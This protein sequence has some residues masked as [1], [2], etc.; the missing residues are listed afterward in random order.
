MMNRRQLMGALGGFAAGQVLNAQVASGAGV[1]PFTLGVA[2][3]EPSSEGFVLWTRLAV[4]PL[5]PDGLGGMSHPVPVSWEVAADETMR[6][7]IKS[8]R[9]E[10]DR[11]FAYSVH[12]EVGGLQPARPYWYR[13]TTLGEQSPIG[14]SLTAPRPTDKLGR[15]RFTVAS[16]SH[17]EQGYFS[18]YRHMAEEGPDLVL[19][20]GDYIY[21]DTTPE[22]YVQYT[23][24]RH[25]GPTAVDLPSYR[26]RYAL[27]RTDQDLQA[28]H[29]T[30]PCLST[31]D[32]HEV[33]NDYANEW[34]QNVEVEPE[35]F[36]RRRAAAYQAYY[37]HMPLRARSIPRNGSVRIFDR[38]RFGE[39]ATFSVLD[40]RQ[41]RSRPACELATTRGG[42]VSLDSCKERLDPQRT[43]LGHYQERWLFD[44][45]KRSDTAWNVIAQ[46]QLVAQLRQKDEAGAGGYWTDGWDGCPAGRQRVLDAVAATKL[47]NPVFFGGDLHSFWAT[48]LKADFGNPWS[49]TLATEFVGTSIT[50]ESLPYEQIPGLLSENPHI[51]YVESRHRGYIAVDLSRDRMEAR[52]QVISDRRN[53]K[54]TVQTLR[55]FAVEN[56]RPGAIEA[57]G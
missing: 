34:S 57:N 23:V 38:Y 39:L 4:D 37:E 24:R 41:Y 50:S 19:F 20:L 51:R 11:R 54:A 10:A 29:A 3:G 12:V 55:R 17:W 2:S 52:F 13:F 27:Y 6:S 33:E 25:D 5:A 9:V 44:G 42:H 32:D 22:K 48:E 46:D 21:E 14:R 16:C 18:A 15:L 7:I 45:F 28:L 56:G 31:W 47:V 35:V 8:G 40:G 26:N 36:L 49:P 43:L 30:A 1:F 53:P